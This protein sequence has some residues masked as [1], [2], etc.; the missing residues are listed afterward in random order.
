M[1]TITMVIYLLAVASVLLGIGGLGLL[2]YGL[3][4]KKKKITISGSILTFVAIIMLITAIFWGARRFFHIMHQNMMKHEMPFPPFMHDKMCG[5]TLMYI[6]DSTSNDSCV[7]VEKKVITG[8]S[9]DKGTQKCTPKN[10]DPSKCKNKCPH[11]N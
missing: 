8:S 11:H 4:N 1:S 7:R 9:Y 2:V 6:N 5:D 10:C 3:I